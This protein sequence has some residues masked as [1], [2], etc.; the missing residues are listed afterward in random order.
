[1]LVAQAISGICP[2]NSPN[3]GAGVLARASLFPKNLARFFGTPST[4]EDARVYIQL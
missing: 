4:G 2:G 1:M 3:A